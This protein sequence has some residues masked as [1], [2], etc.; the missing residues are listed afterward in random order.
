LRSTRGGQMVP[1]C[2]RPRLLVWGGFLN[3]VETEHCRSFLSKKHAINPPRNCGCLPFPEGRPQ[4]KA[5]AAVP[6]FVFQSWLKK[7]VSRAGK[8]PSTDLPQ[9]TVFEGLSGLGLTP[10]RPENKVWHP[11]PVFRVRAMQTRPKYSHRMPSV[12]SENDGVRPQARLSP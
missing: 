3:R 4:A 5:D 2:S 12:Q 9:N 11:E 8:R 7:F 6:K 1:F 10:L